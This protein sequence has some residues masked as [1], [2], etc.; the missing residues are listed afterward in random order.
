[1]LRVVKGNPTKI[2]L[3]R[4]VRETCS[5]IGGLMEMIHNYTNGL[6][7][8]QNVSSVLGGLADQVLELLVDLMS[9]L[10]VPEPEQH[11]TN[12][13]GH[14]TAPETTNT[15]AAATSEPSKFEWL[16]RFRFFLALIQQEPSILFQC[17]S[18]DSDKIL[19]C[20]NI[21]RFAA[22]YSIWSVR[23]INT[24]MIERHILANFW[25]S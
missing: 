22:E 10:G 14:S 8:S 17:M 6:G 21:L 20:S 4:L 2:R 3:F 5:K 12:G 11:G 23:P 19:R 1:M 13:E 18:G 16:V 15:N 25:N 9:R 24:I 7:S